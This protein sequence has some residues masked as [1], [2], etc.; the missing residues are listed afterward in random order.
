MG[1]TQK[2]LLSE[3]KRINHYVLQTVISIYDQLIQQNDQIKS[4]KL[5]SKIPITGSKTN[6]LQPRC[7]SKKLHI[8]HNNAK[9][10]IDTEAESPEDNKIPSP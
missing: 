3:E 1:H 6:T 10:E 2:S 4:T 5:I 7:K 9:S 8:A